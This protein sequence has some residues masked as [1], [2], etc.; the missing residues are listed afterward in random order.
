MS[1]TGMGM[2]GNGNAA[3]HSRTCLRTMHH[4]AAYTDKTI[5]SNEGHLLADDSPAPHAKNCGG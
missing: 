5:H 2:G 1:Q 3:S 4:T